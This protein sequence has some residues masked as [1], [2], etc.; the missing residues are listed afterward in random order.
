M[1][2]AWLERYSRHRAIVEPIKRACKEVINSSTKSR[3]SIRARPLLIVHVQLSFMPMCAAQLVLIAHPAE[4][5]RHIFARR[6]LYGSLD[7]LVRPGV[8]ADR[9]VG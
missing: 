4:K 1:R 7:L 3:A 6:Q 9:P 2:P 5:M 8:V